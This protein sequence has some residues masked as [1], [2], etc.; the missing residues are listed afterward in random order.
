MQGFEK[1]TLDTIRGEDASYSW[2][3]EHRFEWT[4]TLEIALSL[5]LEGKSIVLITD[6]DRKWFEHYI[7]R[8][9][10]R[11]ANTR[12]MICIASIDGL[13]SHFDEI[14]T[15]Q[16]LDMI[17][18]MLG[19]SMGERYFF[20]YIGKGDNKRADIAKRKDDSLLWTFDEDSLN[21]FTMKSFDPMLD[22][23]LLQLFHLFDLSLNAAL[24]G[25]VHV[26]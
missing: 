25:E 8:F 24:F 20:W 21:A 18:D 9:L 19:V 22:I 10:N 16:S 14:T 5:I 23:K 4:K 11:S 12:P 2:L 26:E 7:L 15:P 3:E 6:H 17:E 13:Y 1:W